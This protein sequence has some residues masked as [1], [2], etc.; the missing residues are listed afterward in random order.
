VCGGV[1]VQRGLVMI[2]K[3]DRIGSARR[4]WACQGDNRGKVIEPAKEIQLDPSKK[5]Q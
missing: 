5:S 1:D 2:F 4:W 3:R